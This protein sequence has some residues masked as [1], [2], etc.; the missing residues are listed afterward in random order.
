MKFKMASDNI[1]FFIVEYYGIDEIVDFVL[2]P[3]NQIPCMYHAGKFS[4]EF[5]TN[6]GGS[7]QISHSHESLGNAGSSGKKCG[8]QSELHSNCADGPGILDGKS[9]Y[10]GNCHELPLSSYEPVILE[11]D[12]FTC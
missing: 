8:S 12:K 3:S 9:Q 2:M 6:A 1:C 4:L 11:K 5:L 10:T 7:D